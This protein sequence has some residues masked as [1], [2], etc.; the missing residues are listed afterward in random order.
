[1]DVEP[2]GDEQAQILSELMEECG[3]L[4]EEGTALTKEQLAATVKLKL[5]ADQG[6]RAGKLGIRNGFRKQKAAKAGAP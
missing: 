6:A 5:N 1:M 2:C 3:L 4:K